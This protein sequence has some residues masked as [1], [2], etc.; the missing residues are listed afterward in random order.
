MGKVEALVK[1]SLLSWARRTSSMSIEE[2][3]KKA[4]VK[5]EQVEAWERGGKRPSIPQLRK[6]CEI[7][8]RPLAVFYL[9]EPPKTFTAMRDYRRLPGEI[10][11]HESPELR[12]EVRRAQYRRE[13]ALDLYQDLEGT[14]PE[15]AAS[16][17]IAE[18]PESLGGKIREL[19]G[20]A[21]E[22]QAQWVT[23]HDAFNNWR[24]AIE[25]KGVLVFQTTTV[26]LEEMRG[27]SLHEAQLPVIV[28]NIKDHPHARVF[29]LLHEFA[30]I[31]LHEGG[32]CDMAEDAFRP[33]EVEKMEVYCNHVAGAA[34]V[35]ENR[36]LRE[37]D[38]TRNQEAKGPN[39]EKIEALARLF[40]VSREV[41]LRRL[42]IFNRIGKGFYSEKR[43]EY[44][45]RVAE[46][47]KRP[48]GFAPPDQ[49][50]LSSAGH[51]FTRLV[52]AG[53]YQDKITASDLSDMLEV[54]M[55]H[56][57]RIEEKVARRM[58]K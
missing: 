16:A 46:Q 29:S 9:P 14:V 25:R 11:G 1:P 13:V 21:V 58:A 37:Y 41:L 26:P 12:F 19:L 4:Q 39:D 17:S 40:R 10:A 22:E 51:S 52:L 30:H 45:E 38:S 53:Y 48:G 3:A 35:P 42:L 7:Y 18:P 54:R 43:A 55:K 49:M 50:A 36:L 47:E 2:A 56:V 23:A 31:L 6:L 28:V 57:P 33:P 15:F 8:K 27:F 24:A 20:V 5:P 34:L 44:Q 32:L